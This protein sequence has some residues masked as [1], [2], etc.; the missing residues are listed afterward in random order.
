MRRIFLYWVPMFGTWLIMAA[1]APFVAAVIARMADPK[2]N[3]AAFGVAY[4]VAILVE[5]PVIMILS[6]STAMVR[7]GES[8]RRL[9]RF[10]WAL[11]ACLTTAMLL[12]VLTPAWT[13]LATRTIGLPEPIADLS[14][15]GLM[16]MTLWPAAIGYRRFFQGLLIRARKTRR[17][18]YGTLVRLVT[19]AA[20]SVGLMSYSE[21]PGAWV[22]TA[23][24]GLGVV[25]EAAACRFMARHEVRRLLSRTDESSP[26]GYHAIASFYW[27]LALTSMISLA[28]HPIVTFALGRGRFPL[29]SLAVLPVVNSLTFV[30]RSVGLAYQEVAIALLGHDD[31]DQATVLRFARL[32]GF[33]AT[34]AMSLIAFTPLA[35][36]WFHDVSGLTPELTRFAIV[37]TRILSVLP[38]LSVLLSMQRAILVHGRRTGP[39]TRATMI[40]L[41]GIL[42]ALIL[43]IGGLDM[44]GA[45]AAAIAFLAGRIGGNLAL[46]VPCQRVLGRRP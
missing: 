36:I 26:P 40:E 15:V 25:T 29:E 33:G 35:W 23:A 43:L 46:V 11:N 20:T 21:L 13:V 28:A 39:I 32:L 38:A 16:M 6:A 17:V 12:L 27:P 30:F 10:T 7:G 44:I 37:P 22:G 8:Y 42:V 2:E 5:S 24:I 31:P 4:A 18:A 19:M 14:R 9:L 1:E 34:A 45:I 41:T 3:L